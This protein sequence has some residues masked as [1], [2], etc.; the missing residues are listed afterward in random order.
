VVQEYNIQSRLGCFILDNTT[1]NNTAVRTLGEIYKWPKTEHRQRRLRCMGHIINLVA[2]AFILEEKAE[3]FEQAL[4][5][6]ERGEDSKDDAVKLWQICGPIGK[7]HYAVIFILRTPQRRHEFKRGGDAC[8]ATELVPKRDNSTRWNSI[9]EMI[10]R[11]LKLRDQIK[12]FCAYT[13]VL[14]FKSEM[15]LDKGI[16]TS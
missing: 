15:V 8:E 3:L 9:Y 2:Q 7:L 16:S 14:D 10:K 11:A 1:N 13:Y 6:A 5:K 12:L 4:A